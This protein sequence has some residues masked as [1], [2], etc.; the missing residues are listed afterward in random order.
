VPSVFENTQ[1]VSIHAGQLWRALFMSSIHHF[2]RG[3]RTWKSSDL[4]DLESS[5]LLGG[6]NAFDN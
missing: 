1:N 5:N 6:H 4:I 2:Y 3:D